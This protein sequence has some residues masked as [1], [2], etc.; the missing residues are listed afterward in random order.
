MLLVSFDTESDAVLDR[1][2]RLA[3]ECPALKPCHAGKLTAWRE[4]NSGAIA[5]VFDPEHLRFHE[6]EREYVDG[7]D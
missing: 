2:L 6:M 4:P 3:Q 7:R 1:V 5:V